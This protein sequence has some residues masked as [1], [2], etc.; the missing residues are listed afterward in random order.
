MGTG[1]AFLLT[2]LLARVMGPES[3]GV[4][5][6]VLSLLILLSIPL[7]AGLPSLA[8]REVAKAE[9]AEDWPVIKGMWF[10][11]VRTILL[12]SAILAGV[13]M[14]LD[15][16]GISWL[17][18]ERYEVFII[19]IFAIPFTGLLI[20]QGAIIR[21]L[22][23]LVVG[24]IPDGIV[25][26]VLP[27]LIIG[28][29]MA[30]AWRDN[31][32]PQYAMIAYVAS[33]VF[34]TLLSGFIIVA[35]MP[36]TKRE[37]KD[38]RFDIYN[39]RRAAY[40]LTIV[41]G[42]QLMY[43]YSDIIILG[44]FHGDV[45][46]GIYRAVGQLGTLVIFGLSTINQLLHTQFSKLYFTGDVAKLQKIVTYSSLGIL[47]LALIPSIALVLGGE[48]VLK[49]AFG[50]GYERGALAL[51]ILTLGQLANAAFGSVGALL[52]MTGHERDAM[53][54]MLYSLGINFILAFILIPPFGI[55]GAALATAI[56][57]FLWNGI[58]RY[59]VRKRLNI[60]SSGLLLVIKGK[61]IKQ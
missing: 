5:S 15:V 32:T 1:L 20:S 21:G 23:R 3:Y 39:W 24:I 19:G 47:S 36:S 38:C 61:S 55:E 29:T 50:E 7:Q 41:G 51:L 16:A 53:K 56:S 31:I 14:I 8:V 10:W 12:Y 13:L 58:L 11:I 49:L 45:E 22:G 59:Y 37:L 34:A 60:E 46:V 9:I 35:L 26:P 27:L 30:F 33:L 6:F 54:G 17:S 52:N 40:P 42:L 43:S 28:L 25:R 18:H 44:L 4:Y 57:L 2:V 48:V